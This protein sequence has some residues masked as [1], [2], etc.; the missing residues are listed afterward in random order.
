MRIGELA[1]LTAVSVR[2]L[3]YYEEQ[4]LLVAERG[5]G[6]RRRYPEGSVDRVRLIQ[7]LYAAGL[8]SR[9]IRELLPRAAN[10][11]ATPE[12]LERLSAER[13]RL[14]GQ[15]DDLVST[16]GELDAVIALATESR[17]TGRRCPQH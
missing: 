1:A 17:R 14:D 11:E 13:R 9:T 12:L 16:R 8:S 6:S 10:G 2:A 4:G 5:P 3:R 15:I 7:R